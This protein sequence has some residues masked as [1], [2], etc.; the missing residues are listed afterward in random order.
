MSS[1]L[2]FD[3][4]STVGYNQGN[5][6]FQKFDHRGIDPSSPPVYRSGTPGTRA[7]SVSQADEKSIQFLS[8]GVWALAAE[9]LNFILTM[10]TWRS[11]AWEQLGQAEFERNITTRRWQLLRRPVQK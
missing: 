7:I 3:L 2:I 6:Y 1:S 5:A 11:D 10:E 8:E 9:K 4:S